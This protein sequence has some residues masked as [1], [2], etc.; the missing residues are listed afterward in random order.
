MNPLIIACIC[1]LLLMPILIV[2]F[3]LLLRSNKSKGGSGDGPGGGPKN[4]SV[5]PFNDILKMKKAPWNTQY[6]GNKERL[7]VSNGVLRLRYVKGAHGGSSGAKIT[8]LPEGKF[9]ADELEFGY[10]VFFPETFPWVK[11]GKLPGVCIGDTSKACA[12]GGAWK[13]NQGSARFMWRSK[14]GKNAYII[15]YLYLPIEGHHQKAYDRQGPGYKKATDAGNRTGHDVWHN[16]L[17]IKK[18]WNTLRMKI[19]MNTPKKANGLFEI[20]VNGKVQRV[21]D[22]LWR[23]DSKVK[24]N[25]LNWVSFFGGGDSSWDSNRDTYTEYKNFWI[26]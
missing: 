3:I 26:T 2:V 11:G 5:V 1:S 18:G 23:D 13:K 25:N 6:L 9:P 17:P 22:V 7:S 12:T 10:D 4:K 24:V 15:G 14:D 16:Q 20:E 8:A 21:D 19:R